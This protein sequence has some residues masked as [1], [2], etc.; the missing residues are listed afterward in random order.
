MLLTFACHTST[1]SVQ[2]LCSA[3]WARP[4]AR[5]PAVLSSAGRLHHRL[6]VVSRGSRELRA[7]ES[8]ENRCGCGCV[9]VD[10]VVCRRRCRSYCRR[11]SNPYRAR[12]TSFPQACT[13]AS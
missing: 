1:H 4:A 13:I 7:L 11:R 10:G 6:W 2:L 9:D 5:E 8:G 3:S 12:R